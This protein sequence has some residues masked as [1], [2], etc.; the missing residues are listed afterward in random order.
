MEFDEL[1]WISVIDTD[2]QRSGVTRMF[3]IQSVPF[4]YMFDKEGNIIG[5]D[6]HG[7]ALN[8]KMNQL[9]E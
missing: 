3:N 5:K 6:L 7:R 2:P 8:I 9:F 4:N 1:P